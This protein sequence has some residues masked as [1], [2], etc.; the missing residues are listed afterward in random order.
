MAYDEDL[1]DRVLERLLRQPGLEQK[2]MFG[3]VSFMVQGNFACGI[4]KNHLCVRVGKDAYDDALGL[5]DA[6]PMDFTG[7]P[8]TGWVFVGPLGTV[9]DET[10][11]EWVERGLSNALSLPPK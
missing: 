2:T 9:D 4:V 6:R 10:L 3:G 1:A 8:M 11:R 5:P 7:N